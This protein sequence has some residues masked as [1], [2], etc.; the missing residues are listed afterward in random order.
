MATVFL[1]H[2]VK[3]HDHTVGGILKF[4]NQTGNLLTAF[5]HPSSALE[6]LIWTTID[7]VNN[8]GQVIQA[9]RAENNPTVDTPYIQTYTGLTFIADTAINNIFLCRGASTDT[10]TSS[11]FIFNGYYHLTN[12]YIGYIDSI[13]VSGTAKGYTN[14]EGD[15]YYG[16]GGISSYNFLSGASHNTFALSTGVAFISRDSVYFGST[17]SGERWQ[18]NFSGRSNNTVFLGGFKNF[19]YDLNN[20]TVLYGSGNTFYNVINYATGG[21][22]DESNSDVVRS[23]IINMNDIVKYS[24][25]TESVTVP[26]CRFGAGLTFRTE[27]KDAA[28]TATTE[29]YHLAVATSSGATTITLPDIFQSG[30]KLIIKDVDGQSST[31]NITITTDDASKLIDGSSA[32]TVS[33][34]YQS[35][36][37][38]Y[39][40][41]FNKWLIT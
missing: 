27:K 39:S 41:D 33:V 22:M 30:H 15:L 29:D 20:L 19:I 9:F 36:T 31:N 21:T 10:T 4:R 17:D 35:T 1:S 5:S 18:S 40:E 25:Y 13:G 26:N 38:I 3:F 11:P 7:S 28:Y 12:D 2:D 34:D 24:A 8:T 14:Y 16:K 32:Y 37:L 23:C 6:N